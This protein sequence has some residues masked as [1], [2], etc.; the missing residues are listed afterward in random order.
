MCATSY[1]PSQSFLRRPAHALE[2]FFK[3][4]TVAVIGATEKAG[5]VGRTIVTNL[6]YSKYEGE[7]YLINPKYETLFD[8]PCYKGVDATPQPVDLAIIITPAK[9]V[10]ALVKSCVEAK[11]KACIIISAGFKEL[12]EAGLALEQ[13]VL[14]LIK[15][16]PMRIIGPNCLG[17]MNPLNGLNAT[18][19]ADMANPGSIAFI[20]QSGAMC[21]SVLDWSLMEGV[22]FSAFVSIG[23]MADVNWG[24]LIEYFATDP[25]TE[26]IL[27]YMESVGDARAFLSAA[28]KFS[29]TKPIIL[30]KA[31][32]TE[33]AAS[34]AAS[35]TGSLAGSDAAFQAAVSRVGIMRVDTISQLFDMALTLS[36]QPRPK[37]PNLTLITNA[38][39]PAV[40]ATDTTEYCGAKMTTIDENT[41]KELSTFLPAAWSHA[42][43]VDILGDASPDTYAKT[44]E[45]VAKDPETDGIL[46]ILTPQ[47]MTDPTRTAE[48]IKPYANIGKPVLASWMGGRVIAR[49]AQIVSEAGIP[50][51]E[52]PDQAAEMFA[53]MYKHERDLSSLYA[54]PSLNRD[55]PN[56]EQVES[57]ISSV[58]K[59]GRTLLT[60]LESKQV[61]EA[62]NIP[63][64]KTVHCN[65]VESAM[66][67]AEEMGYPVVLKLH[68]E[69][70][71][72][73]TD[74]GGVKLNIR[75]AEAVKTAFE[76][77][78]TSVT[79]LK[80]AEHFG[81]VTVQQMIKLEGYEL[82]L[83]SNSDPQFGPVLLFG[84]GGQLVEV[85]KDSALA[86]PPLNTTLAHSLMQRT[87]VYEALKGVRGRDPVDIES[88]EQILINFSRLISE[89]SWIAECD[90][91]PLLASPENLV[92]LDARIVLHEKEEDIPPLAIRPYPFNY[93]SHHKLKDG[94]EITL[95]PI[96]PEDEVAITEFH[97]EL[98]T[99][100]VRQNYFD[101][102]TLDAR[103]S[104]DRLIEICNI[105]Y[106]QDMRLVAQNSH[107]EIVGV[108]SL[109]R[110]AGSCEGD[111]R[112]IIVDKMHRKGLGTLLLENLIT[113]AK[114]E[115]F[116]AIT[117]ATLPEN[118]GLLALTNKLG[119]QHTNEDDV[120]RLRKTL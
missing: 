26:S 32:K 120:V 7:T 12:G 96:A 18:F 11:V 71:T 1:D 112:L 17:V 68:S 22:G 77:I 34:A 62:Y 57:I 45:V 39:G 52:Y 83:G 35:H 109:M 119:F 100:S 56:R 47:D 73:K 114:K 40:L 87:K 6:I 58:R 3:P 82:I 61:L 25:N 93:L 66:R 81:G 74:V 79:R 98:S 106:D 88:L 70:I 27:I 76:Q 8:K 90:I 111:M 31:G 80:G 43:P 107:G 108:I 33:A 42:N 59:E 29:L 38:G 2:A 28:K 49:G 97:K 64:V 41:I 21:T 75:S 113:I 84:T 9:T 16:S 46:V 115:G 105:D 48:A 24:D 54:T 55:H 50:N 44:I 51:F 110:F 30:I 99:E 23:S 86:L 13:E 37:G 118:T 101:F 92:A 67:A 20:S 102:M 36:K 69:T 89:N 117:G 5:S 65:D 10:P 116:S 14:D 95:R 63:I 85:Y 104:H 72:H 19:A 94:T 78:Q 15:D 91:N 60:E 4:K 103:T 53:L